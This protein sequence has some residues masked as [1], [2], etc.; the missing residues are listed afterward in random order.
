[1]A[2]THHQHIYLS[3]LSPILHSQVTAQPHASTEAESAVDSEVDSA[4]MEDSEA[5]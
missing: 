5:V 1:M 2:P 4:E 3:F